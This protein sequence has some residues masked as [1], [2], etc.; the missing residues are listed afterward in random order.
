MSNYSEDKNKKNKDLEQTQNNQNVVGDA[1][2]NPETTGPAEN[3]REEAAKATD[4]SSDEKE[5][6]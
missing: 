6:A 1:A 3:L 2:D 4:N 5:P